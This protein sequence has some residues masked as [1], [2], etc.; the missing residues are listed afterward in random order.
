MMT[1]KTDEWGSRNIECV[2][3]VMID[4]NIVVL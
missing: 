1:S 4:V 2:N 3:D